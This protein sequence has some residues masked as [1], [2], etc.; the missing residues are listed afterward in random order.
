MARPIYTP[1]P[2]FPSLLTKTH[3][4]PFPSS[5]CGINHR[6]PMSKLALMPHA[7]YHIPT[8]P[9]NVTISFSFSLRVLLQN[10]SSP[11]LPTLTSSPP[12]SMARASHLCHC[13]CGSQ[14]ILKN[15]TPPQPSS[16]SCPRSKFT[17]TPFVIVRC[18]P[19]FDHGSS[20]KKK[21]A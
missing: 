6:C 16:F 2:P 21:D 4:R 14:S 3:R 13:S 12:M 11:P 19:I 15:L 9:F 7:S 20:T 17:H 5:S 10:S 8:A 1:S 18:C